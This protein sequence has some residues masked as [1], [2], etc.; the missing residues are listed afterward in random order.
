MH[1]PEITRH[2][3]G[4][5][6]YALALA[7]ALASTPA[8]AQGDAANGALMARQWCAA[9]HLVEASPPPNVA[10]GAPP[11]SAVADYSDERVRTWLT[12]PRP[13]MPDFNLSR[14]QI[15]DIIAYLRSLHDD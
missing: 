6:F 1:R 3:L 4:V 8:G 13:P 7:V 5:L 15:G 12:A 14:T 10:D 9:C 11:F 2:R